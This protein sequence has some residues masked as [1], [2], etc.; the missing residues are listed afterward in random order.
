MKPVAVSTTIARPRE[1]V[2]AFLDVLA[3][4]ESF[5]DHFLVDWNLSGP[6]RG[7][8]AALEARV[9]TP[10]PL[11]DEKLDL[12][13]VEVDEPAR[14]T[15]LS[16]GAKGK[17]RTRGTYYLEPADGDGARTDVRF[18]IVYEAAPF[19]ERLT[20]PLTA[21]YLRKQNGRAMERLRERLEALG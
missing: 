6:T 12:T 19:I 5:T 20:A 7:I 15:E 2:F 14:I 10:G 21:A 4:H 17:R 13:V 1:E 3:N 16:V 9:I 8:G 11:P 18:E